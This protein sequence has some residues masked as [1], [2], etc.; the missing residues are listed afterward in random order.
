[1]LK[2]LPPAVRGVVAAVLLGVNT[3][4]WCTLLF[5]LSLVKLA[6]PVKARGSSSIAG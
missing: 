3:L 1:M 2:S 6:I 5:A 4:F